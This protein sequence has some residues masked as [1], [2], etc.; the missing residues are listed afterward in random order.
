MAGGAGGY[1]RGRG[2]ASASRSRPRPSTHKTYRPVLSAR[3]RVGGRV[4]AAG[5]AARSARRWQP[6]EVPPSFPW[7]PSKG[8]PSLQGP[9]SEERL[10]RGLR[11]GCRRLP[12]APHPTAPR[13]RPGCP[14]LTSLGKKANSR[15]RTTHKKDNLRL[16]TALEGLGGC[17]EGRDQRDVSA[18]VTA[19]GL[20]SGRAWVT[21]RRTAS[22]G[23][24][25]SPA[26]SPGLCL[27][28]WSARVPGGGLGRG[29]GRV[30]WRFPRTRGTFAS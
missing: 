21:G 1:R 15:T 30:P 8:V 19:A 27:G 11:P 22:W 9:S 16:F 12:P 18:A 4:G 17:T 14:R 2:G 13:G 10:P 24:P 5:M 20:A 7:P 23:P 6:S 25:W 28:R 3:G 26:G 29:P